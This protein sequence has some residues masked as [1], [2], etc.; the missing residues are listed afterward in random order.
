MPHKAKNKPADS[1]PMVFKPSSDT[2][3]FLVTMNQNRRLA[4]QF[5]A[6]EL[7][8]IAQSKWE[9]VLQDLLAMKFV[10]V[11]EDALTSP[12]GTAR[13]DEAATSQIDK[14]DIHEIID[15]FK[16]VG[17]WCEKYMPIITCDDAYNKLKRLASTPPP[18]LAA[19]ATSPAAAASIPPAGPRGHASYAGAAAKNLNPAAPPF[20]RG[21]PCA[22]AVQPP[23]QTQQPVSSKRSKRLFYATRGP[24][25]RQFFIEAP[26][27]PKDTSLPSMVK[28]ANNALTRAKSTLRVDSARFSPRGITCATATVPTTSDLDIIKATLSGGLLGARVCIPASRSFIKI[29]DVPFFKP[30]T[31]KPI[32]SAEVGAQLQ[33]SIIPSDYVVHWRFV[34]NSP[35][36]KF[37]TVWINLSDSQ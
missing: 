8:S 35:K 26:N 7:M 17:P 36:A 21:P 2:E 9:Q 22:P 14:D 1:A 16:V 10:K 30:G 27:I 34:H 28:L 15:A 5:T 24:S 4:S 6:M 31:T 11:D 13:I 33:H 12:T 32:P 23:T 37:A 29:I 18:P 19:A 25:R 20:V 3:R